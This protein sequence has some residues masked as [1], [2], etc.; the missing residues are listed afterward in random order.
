MTDR[1][2][3]E[4]RRLPVTV[5][6]GFLGAGKTTI[7]NQL[8]QLPKWPAVRC[9]STEARRGRRRSPS[10]RTDRQRPGAARLRAASAAAC[11]RPG[12]RPR[13]L[14]MRALRREIGPL[15]R[16]LIGTTGLMPSGASDPHADAEP[17]SS[18]RR[19]R[20]DGVI[21]AVDASH[22]MV[23]DEHRRR[24]ARWRWPIAR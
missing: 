11:R 2:E 8:V 16:V 6:T 17:P 12:T 13:G 7:L 15:R 4:D 22:A 18:P 19:F 14:F 20:C 10:R 3:D 21:T 1:G 9:S 24:C 5:L 23:L